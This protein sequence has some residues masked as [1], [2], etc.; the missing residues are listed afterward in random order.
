M[1][2]PVSGGSH[3]PYE[4]Y[5]PEKIQKDKNDRPL[6]GGQKGDSQQAV[7]TMLATYIAFLFKK[8]LHLFESTAVSE[9]DTMP[10]CE[11]ANHLQLFKEALEK[12]AKEDCSQNAEFI[13]EL[14]QRWRI[15]LTDTEGLVRK[16]GSLSLKIRVLIKNILHY[17]QNSE[18]TFGYYLSEHVGRKWLPFPFMAMIAG[19][20]R[21]YRTH[22]TLSTLHAWI[23]QVDSILQMIEI[24]EDNIIARSQDL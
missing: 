10:A 5:R 11:L 1:Q 24:P 22:P 12:M 19:L 7:W 13:D 15:L 14:S 16:G 21:E 6:S 17:P 4:R 23:A 2:P 3:D 20:Q 9:R 8:L 18:H